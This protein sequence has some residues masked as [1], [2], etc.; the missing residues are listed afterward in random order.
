MYSCDLS[1]SLRRKMKELSVL[2][3]FALFICIFSFYLGFK[4]KRT[5]AQAIVFGFTILSLF[6]LSFYLSFYYSMIS[7]LISVWGGIMS[8]LLFKKG[9]T[10]IVRGGSMKLISLLNW[11]PPILASTCLASVVRYYSANKCGLADMLITVPFSLMCAL[12]IFTCLIVKHPTNRY[13]SPED[14]KDE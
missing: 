2:D 12:F 10:K 4:E 14:K 9:G 7:I 3:I 11:S 1:Q 5:T 8:Y 6:V 13:P